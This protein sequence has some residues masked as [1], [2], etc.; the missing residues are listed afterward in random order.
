MSKTPQQHRDARTGIFNVSIFTKV[1]RKSDSVIAR[2]RSLTDNHRVRYFS[3]RQAVNPL[4]RQIRT[5]CDRYGITRKRFKKY[6]KPTQAMLL[7]VC[8]AANDN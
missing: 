5:V 1:K 3:G 2:L 8:E 4:R 7:T 6:S